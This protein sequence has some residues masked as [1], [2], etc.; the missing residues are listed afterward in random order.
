M[1]VVVVVVTEDAFKSVTHLG[2]EVRN[3]VPPRNAELFKRAEMEKRRYTTRGTLTLST[4]SRTHFQ[5]Y[6][7][8]QATTANYQAAE[9]DERPWGS[10]LWKERGL[11]RKEN[12]KRETHAP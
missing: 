1:M 3:L 2:G 8:V 7:R 6:T 4:Q 12:T 5:A 11:E 10:H 9:P